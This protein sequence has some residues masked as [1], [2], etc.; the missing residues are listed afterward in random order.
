MASENIVGHDGS[1]ALMKSFTGKWGGDGPG[2]KLQTMDM[3]VG[4]EQ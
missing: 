3:D 4:G 1:Q 2:G